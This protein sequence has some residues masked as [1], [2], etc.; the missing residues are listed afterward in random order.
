M[1]PKT[2]K[3]RE[4]HTKKVMSRKIGRGHQ[5]LAGLFFCFG[6]KAFSL[7]FF[8]QILFL[9]FPFTFIAYFGRVRIDAN[10]PACV[11]RRI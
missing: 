11:S 7:V 5:Q 10:D 1:K 3:N 9:N 4:M 2:N 6:F 8:L